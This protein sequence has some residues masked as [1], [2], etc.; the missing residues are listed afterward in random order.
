MPLNEP[1]RVDKSALLRSI[2]LDTVALCFSEL[3]L[4]L[5]QPEQE[6]LLQITTK[7]SNKFCFHNFLLIVGLS[8]SFQSRWR[9]SQYFLLLSRRFLIIFVVKNYIERKKRRMLISLTISKEETHLAH[10]H[11]NEDPKPQ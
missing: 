1:V 6:W 4:R 8:G 10:A 9:V 7:H 3:L 2:L 5:L 11:W